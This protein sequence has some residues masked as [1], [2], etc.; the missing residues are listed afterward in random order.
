M[1][2]LVLLVLVA[3]G[4]VGFDDE[5]ADAGPQDSGPPAPPPI[6]GSYEG[7]T[8]WTRACS[9]QATTTNYYTGTFAPRRNSAGQLLL[10]ATVPIVLDLTTTCADVPVQESKTGGA[11]VVLSGPCVTQ[12][13]GGATWQSS[14]TGG[15]IARQGDALSL[16]VTTRST[17][18]SG[19]A[20]NMTLEGLV[21]RQ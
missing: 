8:K 6:E 14:V 18:S 15:T 13:Y 19:A 10:T 17:S 21:P 16:Y 5:L 4:G 11:P 20:C 7:Q 9:G 3:C 12:F 2:A 1:R